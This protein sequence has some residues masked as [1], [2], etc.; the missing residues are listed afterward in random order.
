MDSRVDDDD[1]DDDDM[2]SSRLITG[3]QQGGAFPRAALQGLLQRLSPMEPRLSIPPYPFMGCGGFQQS[4]GNASFGQ[5]SQFQQQQMAPL[6]G[7]AQASEG[8]IGGMPA[9]I[10]WLMEQM[11]ERA[12]ELK[13]MQVKLEAQFAQ[14]AKKHSSG[15]PHG[16]ISK[17]SKFSSVSAA[18]NNTP[19]QVSPTTSNADKLDKLAEPPPKLNGSIPGAK[20]Q[21]TGGHGDNSGKEAK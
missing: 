10:L 7:R 12:N 13:E 21:D 3:S 11:S 6:G 4:L 9:E 15:T 5:P 20:S 17:S 1:D 18:T 19:T 2:P 14:Y 16:G 8:S